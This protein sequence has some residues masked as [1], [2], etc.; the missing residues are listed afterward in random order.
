MKVEPLLENLESRDFWKYVLLK[1]ETLVDD[2]KQLQERLKIFN[3]EIK[4]IDAKLE[5]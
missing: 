5:K 3:Y 4:F 1:T 2:L